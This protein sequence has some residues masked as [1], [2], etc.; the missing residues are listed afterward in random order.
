MI[1]HTNNKT[2]LKSVDLWK[3]STTHNDDKTD[4]LTHNNSAEIYHNGT[5][6]KK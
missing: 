4:K 2:F 1:Y 3:M 6:D 5:N